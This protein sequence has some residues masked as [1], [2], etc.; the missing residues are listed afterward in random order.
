MQTCYMFT[1]VCEMVVCHANVYSSGLGIS[2]FPA[3][4]ACQRI[5]G[6]LK[7]SL[8]I[9]GSHAISV[10]SFASGDARIAR[11]PLKCMITAHPSFTRVFSNNT[12]TTKKSTQLPIVML[13]FNTKHTQTDE[14]RARIVA[15]MSRFIEYELITCPHLLKTWCF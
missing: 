2:R 6:V 12:Q 5:K 15:T 7:K 8:V 11:G 3:S 14:V 10:A 9:D 13:L 4:F 1:S